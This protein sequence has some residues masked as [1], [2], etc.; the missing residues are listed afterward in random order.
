MSEHMT[1]AQGHLV[2][3]ERVSDL[4]K[5]KHQLVTSIAHRAQL[6]S[7]QLADFKREALE[8]IEAFTELS[9]ERYGAK[10]GGK[11]GNL[12]L[13]SFDGSAKIQIAISDHMVFDERLQ[14]AK[15]LIDECINQWMSQSD[16]KDDAHLNIK[17]LVQHAFQVDKEGQVN[18]GRILGLKQIDIKDQKWQDAMRAISDS[19]TVIGTTAYLRIYQRADSGAR[20]EQ[21]ALDIANAKPAPG[22]GGT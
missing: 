1:N 19:I 11:K 8:D 2:P 18:R 22:N 10:M 12:S 21:I 9:A 14:I 7:R 15:T 5:E 4:D 3:V 20:F 6:L 13:L 16:G 17:A